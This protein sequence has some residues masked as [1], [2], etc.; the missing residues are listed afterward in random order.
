[1]P[2]ELRLA[3]PDDYAALGK[4]MYDSVRHG[5]SPYSDTQRQ[6]WMPKPRSGTE[7]NERLTAQ[8]IIIAETS[9]QIL[10]FMSLTTEGYV[11]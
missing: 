10:G 3:T 4:V 7:W 9:D 1:M 8:K 6:A 5:D 2:A 11:D